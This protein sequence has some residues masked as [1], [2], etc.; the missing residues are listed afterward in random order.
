MAL[1]GGRLLPDT[2]DLPG[3]GG[4]EIVLRV[5]VHLD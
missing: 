2:G 4:E 1:E 3:I 5:L